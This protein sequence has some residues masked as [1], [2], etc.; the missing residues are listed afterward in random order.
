MF[1][2]WNH[3]LFPGWIVHSKI[4]FLWSL[5]QHL[6]SARTSQ[7]TPAHVRSYR[8][9]KFRCMKSVH[10]PSTNFPRISLLNL[11]LL[12]H[13]PWD[14]NLRLTEL[15][16]FLRCLPSLLLIL[17]TLSGMDFLHLFQIVSANQACWFSWPLL[18]NNTIT[19]WAA[20]GVDRYNS[21]QEG[22]R[23]TVFMKKCLQICHLPLLWSISRWLK[24]CLWKC[25][26]F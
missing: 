19:E 18:G 16:I 9:M 15:G 20:A 5:P 26:Q 21:R 1:Y 14:W 10:I 22:W 24:R 4:R 3:L 25:C 13:S 11:G 23:W 8:C 6:P 7:V 17:A 12:H 2:P